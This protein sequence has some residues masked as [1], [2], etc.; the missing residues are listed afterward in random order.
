MVSNHGDIYGKLRHS[1]SSINVNDKTRIAM[2]T[3]PR[4]M[5]SLHNT[6]IGANIVTCHIKG[7][8]VLGCDFWKLANE[9]ASLRRA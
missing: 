2:L 8:R 6:D 1:H 4:V 3:R 5:V 9:W 7:C